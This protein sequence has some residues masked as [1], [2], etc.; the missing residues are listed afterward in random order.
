MLSFKISTTVDPSSVVSL[1]R[2]LLPLDLKDGGNALGS[3]LHDEEP[4][5]EG[6]EENV[7]HL[8]EMEKLKLRKIL[9][10]VVNRMVPKT[11]AEKQHQGGLA[12]I[13]TWEEWMHFTGSS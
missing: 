11:I 8:S 13:K 1:I 12:Q 2:K 10:I 6:I 9:I 3:G 4:K 7:V 5:S